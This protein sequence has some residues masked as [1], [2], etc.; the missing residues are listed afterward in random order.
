MSSL[1]ELGPDLRSAA[2]SIPQD[3]GSLARY[4]ARFGA[5]LGPASPRQF[6]GGFGN[7]NSLIEIDGK[8][9]V[10]R[11]PPNGPL[12]PGANDMA[13]EFG[14]LSSLW[15]A[16]PLAPRGMFYCAAVGVLG[17]PFQ[18]IEYPLGDRHPRHS[19]AGLGRPSGGRRDS[20]PAVGREPRYAARC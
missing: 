13:R 5:V 2:K 12:P 16:Y 10:L 17:A 15:R 6:A 20:E 9:T 14:I 1:R 8:P 7:L 3:W 4:L 18:I 19:A 11:R